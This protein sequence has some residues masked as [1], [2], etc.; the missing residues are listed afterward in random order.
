MK[1]FIDRIS[2]KPNRYKMTK[3]TDGTS[4]YVTMQLEDEPSKA[5]TP[6][7]REA[8]MAVQGFRAADTTISKS[9]NV[10]TIIVNYA[11][12]GKSEI[13]ITKNSATETVIV[14]KY[15]GNSGEVITKTVTITKGTGT[16]IK[17]VLA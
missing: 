13:T 3:E 10:T 15:T 5:G 2:G 7:N 12:G 9:G 6:L 17:E 11:D 8:F 1:D 14:D 4:E 16:T